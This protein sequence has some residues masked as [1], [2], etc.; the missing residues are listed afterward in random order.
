MTPPTPRVIAGRRADDGFAAPWRAGPWWTEAWCHLEAIT[1]P[2]PI[3]SCCAVM[4]SDVCIYG[5]V[6]PPDPG[7]PS[8]PVHL[9]LMGI[10]LPSCLPNGTTVAIMLP[11]DKTINHSLIHLWA[12]SP[13]HNFF[14]QHEYVQHHK[15]LGLGNVLYSQNLHLL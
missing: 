7:T 4:C 5:R 8:F 12:V 1:P 15:H 10:P 2:Q 3:P 11:Y 13:H 6:Q 14:R 9:R